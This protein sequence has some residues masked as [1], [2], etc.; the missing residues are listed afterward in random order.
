MIRI[1]AILI[2]AVFGLAAPA[3][4]CSTQAS[5]TFCADGWVTQPV[6][7][8]AQGQDP[9][10]DQAGAWSDDDAGTGP[11]FGDEGVYVEGAV[12]VDSPAP[13]DDEPL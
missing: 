7:R 11:P 5:S 3:R 4:A 12:A 6:E 1:L 8:R 9:A 10:A 2:L 13:G